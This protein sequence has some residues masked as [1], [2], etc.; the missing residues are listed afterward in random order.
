MSKRTSELYNLIIKTHDANKKIFTKIKDK[1]REKFTI[2]HSAKD[3][4]Y[5]TFNFIE[6]N[7]DSLS[8][9]LS[10]YLN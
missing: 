2:S 1:D 7:S 9:S 8:A 10:N 5:D 4:K 3:V 6:S